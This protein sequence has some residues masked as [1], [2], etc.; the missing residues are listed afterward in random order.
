VGEAV[1]GWWSKSQR[2]WL[3][4]EDMN[5]HHLRAAFEKLRRREYV[6]P[7]HDLTEHDV[8]DLLLA[9]ADEFERRGWDENGNAPGYTKPEAAS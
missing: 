6:H 3:V 1:T 5:D 4:L 9:F 8:N 7:E 2:K